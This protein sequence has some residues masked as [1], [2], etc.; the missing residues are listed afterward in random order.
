[1][2]VSADNDNQIVNSSIL[3]V[4]A[5]EMNKGLYMPVCGHA[6][7]KVLLTYLFWT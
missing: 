3:S 4:K 7:M 6:I 2:S 5:F 1:M